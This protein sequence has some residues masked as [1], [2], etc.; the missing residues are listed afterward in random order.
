[1]EEVAAETFIQTEH[2]AEVPLES[3]FIR[4]TKRAESETV[5]DSSKEVTARF[6][7]ARAK[8]TG[9]D[10]AYATFKRQFCVY[11]RDEKASNQTF[12][13]SVMRNKSIKIGTSLLTDLIGRFPAKVARFPNAHEEVGDQEG[14]I[15]GPAIE[16]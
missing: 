5:T 7:E 9:T 8:N 1:M 3:P 12:D 16:S 15:K 14:K 6:R 10:N 2:A 4:V 13:Y 11:C